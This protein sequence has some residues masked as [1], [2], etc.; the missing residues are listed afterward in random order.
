MWLRGPLALVGVLVPVLLPGSAYTGERTL[1]GFALQPASVDPAEIQAGG[2]PRD[3]IPALDDPAT[4]PA[5]RATLGDAERVLGVSIEGESRAYPLAVL[6]WHELVNDRLGGRPILVTYCPLCGTGLVFDRRVDGRPR[7]FGVSGLLYRSDLLMFDRET[8]SL[9]S[10]IRADAVTGSER[11]R[12]LQILRSRIEPWGAWRERHPDTDVLSR[13]TG[14][15][16]PYGRSPYG[17]YVR[18]RALYFPVPLDP[19]APD[20]R[21]HPKERTVGL[22]SGGRARAYPRSELRRAGGVVEE[23]FAGVKVRVSLEPETGAFAVEA[24]DGI[25]VVEGYW[26]AWRA[27]HP[28]ASTFSASAVAQEAR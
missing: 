7:R 11:G 21:R 13:A 20:D 12:R 19:A 14:F 9:W 23:T 2:P 26:F 16:R 1:N 22:R 15:R 18:S 4:L 24:S 25:E 5:A 10:Q 3:G 27:F 8:D 28:G 6:E 17:D